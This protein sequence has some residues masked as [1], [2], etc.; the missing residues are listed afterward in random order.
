MRFAQYRD[1]DK[2]LGIMCDVQT[3]PFASFLWN[4]LKIEEAQVT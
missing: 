3:V 1:I 4:M 2:R